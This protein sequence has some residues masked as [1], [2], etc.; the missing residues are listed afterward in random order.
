M[1][2]RGSWHERRNRT[3]PPRGRAAGPARGDRE[4][5][6]CAVSWRPCSPGSPAVRRFYDT[7]D[8]A[9]AFN[10]PRELPTT[11]PS[12]WSAAANTLLSCGAHHAFRHREAAKP[13]G[14]SPRRRRPEFAGWEWRSPG[15]SCRTGRNRCVAPGIWRAAPHRAA[16]GAG[17]VV[18]RGVTISD[19][20]SAAGG[21]DPGGRASRGT[22]RNFTCRLPATTTE[23]LTAELARAG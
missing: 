2:A 15:A 17:T 21:S 6:G 12:G 11:P 18:S 19:G 22:Y 10:R 8:D 23:E 14:V 3:T 13:R 7:A 5:V 9:E 20:G 1:S 16:G 4:P